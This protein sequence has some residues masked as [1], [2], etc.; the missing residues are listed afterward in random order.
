MTANINRAVTY[1][2]LQ[3][4]VMSTLPDVSIM[5]QMVGEGITSVHYSLY[6]V[7]AH[8]GNLKSGHYYA[9]V[10]VKHR[11]DKDALQRRFLLADWNDPEAILQHVKNSNS[12]IEEIQRQDIRSCP[13]KNMETALDVE[14]TDD[15]TWYYISDT[16]V[17]GVSKERALHEK[18]AYMLFYEIL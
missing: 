18:C 2:I 13:G 8:A 17:I 11:V 6:S 16:H 5:F 1:T 12:D 9:Y 3:V 10:K 7:V 15:D 4:H 14:D